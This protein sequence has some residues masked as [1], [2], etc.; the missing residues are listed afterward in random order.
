MRRKTGG[1]RRIFWP[2]DGD[3]EAIAE[4]E[5]MTFGNDGIG[6]AQIE[7]ALI[8]LD[9]KIAPLGYSRGSRGVRT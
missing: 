6:V 4:T 2:G 3:G 8:A 7:R 9:H 1:M 5:D